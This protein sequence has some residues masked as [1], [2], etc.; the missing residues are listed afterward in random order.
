[1]KYHLVTLG[2]PKNKVDSDGIEMLLRN[3]DYR[4]TDRQQ[5]A[6]VLIVNTCGFLEASKEESISVLQEMGRRK[7]KHQVL[8]AAGCLVQRNGAEVLERVPKVDGLLGTRRWMEVLQLLEQIRRG[9]N[10]RSLERY[11]L[12]GEAELAPSVEFLGAS[13]TPALLG[14]PAHAFVM[15]TPRP[16]VTAGSAYLKISDGCN[17]PCAFCTI[18]SFKGKLRSRPLEAIV[19]EAVALVDAGARELVIVAQDTTDYGRD[20]GAPNSLPRLLTAICQRTDERLRWVRL[21]YA[22][23]GHVSDELIE[24]MAT[25]PKIAPYLDMPLQHGD[26]RTLRRMHRPSKLEMVYDHVEKLR[27]AM[28]DI[29]LRTTFIVGYPGETEEE[30]QGLLDFVRAIEFD[31]VGAFTFSPEP[32]TPAAALPDQTPDEVKQERYAR[33]MELQQ[34]ISLRKNQAQVGKVLEVLVEGEGEIE[35]SGEPLLL[36]RSYRDAPEIDGLVLAPGVRG[37]QRGEMIQV[38]INGAMEYDLVG[39]PLVTEV[40]SSKRATPIALS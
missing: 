19:D 31:K 35:G 12:L 20:L 13:Q 24:V 27:A 6:D 21:M 28:P 9:K 40:F 38:H 8:V 18:P 15:A 32:G 23:P 5:D 17:A 30:F 36:A 22:Y 37:V 39:E 7:R 3:A 1:M 33:L 10:R 34:P 11:T 25:Q 16:P 26:P 14:D 2:C 29:A 4:P